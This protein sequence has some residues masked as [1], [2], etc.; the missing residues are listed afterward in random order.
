MLTA[1]DSL[2]D[3]VRCFELGATDYITKPFEMAELR[4]VRIRASL[5]TKFLQDQLTQAR[6]ELLLAKQSAETAAFASSAKSDF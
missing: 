4:V 3:K 5:R 6:D 2:S 1:W